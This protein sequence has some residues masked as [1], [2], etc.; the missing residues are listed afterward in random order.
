MATAYKATEFYD[1]G[2]SV[3]NFPFL[4][5]RKEFV[6]ARYDKPDG[7]IVALTYNRDYS[8]VGQTLTLTESGVAACETGDRLC[9]YRE[10][11]TD[12]LVTYA[13]ASVLKAYDM[14]LAEVQLLHL[15]EENTD[16]IILHSLSIDLF[17]NAWE[18]FGHRLKDIADPEE[19]QDAVTLH[20][21]NEVDEARIRTMQQIQENMQNLL[22]QTRE[23]EAN[24][25][26]HAAA[27]ASSETNAAGSATNAQTWAEGTDTAVAPLGGEHSA[28]GWA[29]LSAQH[30]AAAQNAITL[31]NVGYNK[32]KQSETNAAASAQVAATSAANAAQ[33]ATNASTNATNASRSA[34]S[35]ATSATSASRSASAASTSESNAAGSANSAAQSAARA[36][37]FAASDYALR[38]TE[39]AERAEAAAEGAIE[40]AHNGESSGLTVDD[41]KEI[42]NRGLDVYEEYYYTYL[43]TD[44]KPLWCKYNEASNSLLLH[45]RT[46]D[47]K[48]AVATLPC[49]LAESATYTLTNDCKTLS[50]IYSAEDL[51][52]RKWTFDMFVL[53]EGVT[54]LDNFAT[55]TRLVYVNMLKPSGTWRHGNENYDERFTGL[56]TQDDL[57]KVTSWK[58]AFSGCKELREVVVGRPL[59]N[60]VSMFKMCRSLEKVISSYQDTSEGG[61]LYSSYQVQFIGNAT[62]M[63]QHCFKLQSLDVQ[64]EN[65]DGLGNFCQGNSSLRYLSASFWLTQR[66]CLDS[67]FEDCILLN[68]VP[69]LN[70]QEGVTYTSTSIGVSA[71]AMF[72]NCKQLTTFKP[73]YKYFY[74]IT[75]MFYGAGRLSDVTLPLST[76]LKITDEAFYGCVSLIEVNA[77]EWDYATCYLTSTTRM[78]YGCHSLKSVPKLYL[79]GSN[80]QTQT[81]GNCT[82]LEKAPEITFGQNCNVDGTFE[83]CTRLVDTSQI[84]I[85]A[86]AS[87]KNLFKGCTSLKAPVLT[88]PDY[89]D[90][91]GLFAD[92][93][94]LQDTSGVIF[95]NQLSKSSS[96]DFS[97]VFKGCSKLTKL[98]AISGGT[99]WPAYFS[100]SCVREA[101]FS[102]QQNTVNVKIINNLFKECPDLLKVVIPSGTF[103]AAAQGSS[104][105]Y[106][107][108][109]LTQVEI[110]DSALPNLSSGRYMFWGCTALTK[111]TF[112]ANNLTNA[113][114]MKDMFYNCT[115]LEEVIGLNIPEGCE[116]SYMFYKCASLRTP[117]Q[118]P[119]I[120]NVLNQHLLEGCASM[121]SVYPY[122]FDF[123]PDTQADLQNM[124]E[125]LAKIASRYENV[126]D[127][128]YL[129]YCKINLFGHSSIT[130]VTI[131]APLTLQPYLTPKL[132]RGNDG[133]ELT[134]HFIDTEP[135][136]GD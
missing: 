68:S 93:I 41:V 4:Y 69:S 65:V 33:S 11:P 82:S 64:G 88:I 28:K 80:V 15:A 37:Q 45:V 84:T 79:T 16:Y 105:F 6:K 118:F 25:R 27:A 55:D 39:A 127:G 49:V 66:A 30:E 61:R 108:P 96:V 9:I 115:A 71:K 135:P 78:F 36:A 67:A 22:S 46:S 91:S 76:W 51:R 95:P 17:D 132:L 94:N 109:S 20:Y 104:M 134:I 53:G 128:K 43:R 130:E 56:F 131:K 92:C 60:P 2:E 3:Y 57:A 126:E 21:L 111:V 74:N 113:T 13:D 24:A 1:A 40:G 42:S 112:G 50:A 54:N 123:T 34:T 10:T 119:R 90:I 72:K 26:G 31:V 73:E 102:D 124:E 86:G 110:G 122:A 7:T 70:V 103:P 85:E 75:Q 100:Q 14:N 98:P 121:P 8:V 129:N 52:Q 12:Q 114:S 77:P 120:S 89:T 58:N 125:Q 23:S 44:E 32:A 97:G 47:N 18:G 38:A 48:T 133:G 136:E 87:L 101:I 106:D 81:F 19:A 63:F 83:G 99:E 107:C 59:N 35:A 5:L 117:I 62:G 29:T 116:V